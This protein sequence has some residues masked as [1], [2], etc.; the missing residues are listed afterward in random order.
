M[1][2]V[3]KLQREKSNFHIKREM[4]KTTTS[5]VK[6]QTYR[7][8]NILKPNI[9]NLSCVQKI[10]IPNL[11]YVCNRYTEQTERTEV[12]FTFGTEHN[13]DILQFYVVFVRSSQL[14]GS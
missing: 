12:Y 1:K 9:P 5:Y 11:P 7:I 13:K 4:E 3:D 10:T 6:N 14:G 2:T 8:P